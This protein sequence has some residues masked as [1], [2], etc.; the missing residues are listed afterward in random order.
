MEVD[1]FDSPSSCAACSQSAHQL[2]ESQSVFESGPL[3]KRAYFG[4]PSR[5]PASLVEVLR[6]GE[7]ETIYFRKTRKMTSLGASPRRKPSVP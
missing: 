2:E 5:Q 4:T 7:K 3:R 6:E 1:G